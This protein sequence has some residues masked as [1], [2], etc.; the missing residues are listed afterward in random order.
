M[1]GSVAF[2][3]EVATRVV[4][5]FDGKDKTVLHNGTTGTQRDEL[6]FVILLAGEGAPG[7]SYALSD[8]PEDVQADVDRILE[9]FERVAIRE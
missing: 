1:R 2:I 9:S 5:V 6:M 3:G 4:L 7:A 8:L